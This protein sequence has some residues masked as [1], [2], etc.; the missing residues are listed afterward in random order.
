VAAAQA[1]AWS[2]LSDPRTTIL[3]A[4]SSSRRC[5][6]LASSH[7]ARIQTSRSPSVVRITGGEDKGGRPCRSPIASKK[8]HRAG[9][10]LQLPA[11]R[12]VK[13]TA[14]W[15]AADASPSRMRP[16]DRSSF[17]IGAPSF[18]SSLSS[19]TQNTLGLSTA[20]K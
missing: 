10:R 14:G 19:A 1:A 17:M 3:R 11:G 4:K 15:N 18:R 12:N 5:S 9:D 8:W 2:S 6:A 7:G 20:S 16:F 13:G